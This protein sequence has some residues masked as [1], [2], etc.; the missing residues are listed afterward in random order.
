MVVETGYVEYRPDEAYVGG[1]GARRRPTARGNI[2]FDQMTPADQVLSDIITIEA[3]EAVLIDAYE[4]P[5]GTSLI[6]HKIVIASYDPATVDAICMR[7]QVNLNRPFDI[8][9][10]KIMDL[11]PEGA[12]GWTLTD[13]RTS[14]LITLPGT[15]QLEC[16]TDPVPNEVMH[17][18][19][20][21]WPLL[22]TPHLPKEYLGG[23]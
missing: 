2:L 3:G 10:D 21:K 8:I 7:E 13:T 9:R 23:F 14:L 16:N 5:V 12:A 4:I 17:V 6:T 18:S 22:A 19:Y 11:G 15:Y 1:V 20:R